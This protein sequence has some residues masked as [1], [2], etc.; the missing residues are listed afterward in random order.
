[1]SSRI[2]RW[3]VAVV[4]ASAMV[5]PLPAVRAG[6]LVEADAGPGAVDP[7][8]FKLGD[9]LEELRADPGGLSYEML[10]SV[11]DEAAARAVVPAGR[12]LRFLPHVGVARTV[13]D[14]EEILR[15]AENPAVE[16]LEPDRALEL[17][18][19]GARETTGVDAVQQRRGDGTYDGLTGA[20][21]HV[22]VI[23]SGLDTTH[24]DFAGRIEHAWELVSSDPE[25]FVAAA[26]GVSLHTGERT[27][28]A[29]RAYVGSSSTSTR[30]DVEFQD[31]AVATGE[32]PAGAGTDN[33]GHGTHV[34]GI[35]GGGGVLDPSARGV[36][37][38]ARIHS[39]KFAQTVGPQT[40]PA[41]FI[42]ES[43]E[44]V[45]A[46]NARTAEDADDIRVVNMS[47]GSPG[48]GKDP[49]LRRPNQRAL[50]RAFEAGVLV[51]VAYGNFG[52]APATC[53]LQGLQ[54]WALSVAN[55]EK[56]GRI[57]G[58]SS[59]GVVIGDETWNRQKPT[60]KW[61]ANHD[62][63]KAIAHAKEYSSD[64]TT[65]DERATWDFDT[66]PLGLHRPGVTAPGTRIVS[67]MGRNHFSTQPGAASAGGPYGMLS[68]TS[69]AAP[70]VAG[71][72]TL[73][74]EAFRDRHGVFPDPLTVIRILEGT[75]DPQVL[76][77][78]PVYDA[79]GALTSLADF[80]PAR[81]HEMGTGY[82]DVQSAV[83]A[84]RSWTDVHSLPKRGTAPPKTATSSELE[85]CEA[86]V[87]TIGSFV[88]DQGHQVCAVEVPEGVETM[89]IVAT[90]IT[91]GDVVAV[92]VSEER[93][94]PCGD[95]STTIMSTS[96]P[97]TGKVYD[98]A[99]RRP[100][101]GPWN[102]RFDGIAPA[103]GTP[104]AVSP[105][106]PFRAEVTFSFRNR[107]PVVGLQVA[108]TEVDGAPVVGVRAV[109]AD[110]DGVSDVTSAMLVV[111]DATGR[112]QQEF[113]IDRFRAG[114]GVLRFAL[115]DL[116]LQ[117]A[118][119]WTVRLSA[120]DAGGAADDHTTV[121]A[122]R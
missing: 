19:A 65:D 96:K 3:L 85:T 31:A 41:S 42:A 120:S 80:R 121:V 72:A 95:R 117:G 68:G 62:R 56:G 32:L 51:T 23:D 35:L 114:D 29:V 45:L 11:D 17:M 34:T 88:T 26:S 122:R 105:L 1:M 64:E 9:F 84:A 108:P 38:A 82:V 58:D 102:V 73:V 24:P 99:V 53:V 59:R 18:N 10:L 93:C 66:K 28:P 71:I 81:P 90:P 22:A 118:G 89:R 87:V 55:G 112:R 49:G 14:R 30:I 100:R 70:H 8:A 103:P 60:E 116:H 78:A 43:F 74:V 77:T 27:D 104:T 7:A 113:G 52:P 2:R 12:P 4:M 75:A 36:A 111:S 101:S 21:I 50:R 25:V 33:S 61:T 57:A 6:V 98:V 39:Y 54:P 83:A 91:A 94:V 67:T 40:V 92:S 47:V 69:M 110:A 44:H 79:N 5:A 107:A 46:H 115:S 16:G 15:V 13:L 48:C 97:V 20:G 76:V 37:P 109:V 119:P 63:D 106:V 86:N